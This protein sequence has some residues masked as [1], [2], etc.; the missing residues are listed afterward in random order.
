MMGATARMY[1]C[2]RCGKSVIEGDGWQ[3][4]GLFLPRR[5]APRTYELC[6]ECTEKLHDFLEKGE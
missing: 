4:Y 3:A 1:R 6:E 2:S 5:G